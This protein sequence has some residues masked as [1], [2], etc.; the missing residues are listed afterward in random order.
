MVEDCRVEDVPLKDSRGILLAGISE[1]G[2]QKVRCHANMLT[3]L[4][5]TACNPHSEADLPETC[6]CEGE[7]VCARFQ[8]FDEAEMGCDRNLSL[9]LIL[10]NVGSPPGSA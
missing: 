7:E 2:G 4:R 5:C 8:S 3:T 9:S 10:A 1:I 6:R